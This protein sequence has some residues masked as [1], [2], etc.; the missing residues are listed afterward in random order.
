MPHRFFLGSCLYIISIIYRFYL[1]LSVSKEGWKGRKDLCWRKVLPMLNFSVS[2]R[3]FYLPREFPQL[4]V[5]LVYIHPKANVD[6]ATLTL[7]EAAPWLQSIAPNAPN[8]IMGDLIRCKPGKSLNNF[9]QYVTCPTRESKCLDLC[10]G[11]TKGA[12]KSFSRAPLETSDH[13]TVY[14]VPT[15]K[16][17]L[18]ETKPEH[19]SVWSTESSQHIQDCFHCTDW[20]MFRESCS[21]LDELTETV[22]AYINFCEDTY[23]KENNPHLS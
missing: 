16:P 7:V 1:L 12:F 17:I 21:D 5:S 13:N 11:S 8:F 20:D 23:S 4:F 15:Y 14:L 10:Y 2:L 6:S 18:K 22:T 3:P 9:Y 19:W